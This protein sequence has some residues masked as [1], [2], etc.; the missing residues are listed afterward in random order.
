MRYFGSLPGRGSSMGD[1]VYFLIA[2]SVVLIFVFPL[3]WGLSTSLRAPMDTFTVTGLGIPGIHFD[4]PGGMAKIFSGLETTAEQCVF[5]DSKE[6]FQ[7]IREHK[8]KRDNTLIGNHGNWLQKVDPFQDKNANL[9][10]GDYLKYYMDSIDAGLDVPQALS[11]ANMQ[12]SEK[13]GNKYVI[14]SQCQ[15]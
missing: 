9:R 8:E 6:L 12:Y 14:Y 1:S 15:S 5:S 7:A 2:V 11:A 13:V 4:M 3:Y 10:V